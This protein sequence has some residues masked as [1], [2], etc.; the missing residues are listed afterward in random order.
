MS[1]EN[2]ESVLPDAS[3]ELLGYLNFSDGT[4]ATALQQSFNRMFLEKDAPESIE[5]LQAS[6]LE[7]LQTLQ[8]SGVPGF[9]DVS[10]AVSAV[11]TALQQVLPAYRKFHADLLFHLRDEDFF[12][13]LFL[14]RIFETTLR[15]GSE[16]GWERPDV[17]TE[18]AVKR[19]NDYVGY[20][21][22]AVLENEQRSEVYDHERYCPIPLYV[23]HV[24]VA[25]G[26]WR[27][28]LTSA[29]SFLEQIPDELTE[30]AHF[31]LER[32]QE[33][34]LD[35]RAHDH[36]HPVNKRTNYMFG[37]W[38][39][40]RIDSRGFYTRFVIRRIIL[41]ALLDWLNSD[42]DIPS[43][44]RLFDASVVLAGTILMAS[45]ISGSGPQTFDSSV[46]LTVLLPVVARY[47]DRFY[48]FVLETTD[49]GRRERLERLARKSRQ[50]FGHVR[51]ELN[52]YLSRY[53]AQQVQHRQLSWL[54]AS[55]GFEAASREEA[56]VIPCPA[57][58]FE[59]EICSRLVLI[60][61]RMRAGETA[62][63]VEQLRQ[64]VR[65]L[66]AGIRC[67]GFVDPWNILGFQGMFP[68]FTAREDAIPDNRVEVLL[69][70]M[71]QIFDA[72]AFVM[73]EAAATG[74]G[75]HHLAVQREFEQ[76]ADWWDRYAT[77]TVADLPQVRGR[78]SLNAAEH[79]SAALSEWRTAGESAADISFW[80]KHVG[81]F[82]SARSFSQVVSVLLDRDDLVAAT[83]LLIQW[84]S[85]AD[86]YGLESGRHSIH[87]QF[88]R[89]LNLITRRTDASEQWMLLRRLFAFLESN[90]GDYWTVPSLNALAERH[91]REQKNEQNRPD[92]EHLFD[93][94][95]AEDD[96][97]KESAFENVVYRDSTDDGNESDTLDGG[98]APGTTEF[99]V[100]YRQIEPRLKFLHTLGFLWSSAAISLARQP[101]DDLASEDV[102]MHVREWRTT[103]RRFL[104]DLS[105]LLQE[106]SDFEIES[107]SADVESNIEFDVQM[108]S[109]FLLMQNAISTTVEFLLAE[110]LIAALLPE[111]DDDDDPADLQFGRRLVRVLR[112][113]LTG[114]REAVTQEFPEFLQQLRRRPLL[115]VPFENGGHPEDILRARTL[116]AVIRLLLSE[117]PRLGMLRE[118]YRLL[119]TAYRMERSRRP[120]GQA[121]TEFDRLFRIGLSGSVES[122][123]RAAVHWK[124]E[125]PTQRKS[126][127]RRIR[128]LLD[129]YVVLWRC[130]R[131]T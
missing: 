68:L 76:L 86:S 91:R 110:R 30:P 49:G 52:M 48:Q 93:D 125:T 118:T 59:A 43:E 34:C 62:D 121:V 51:H 97:W 107:W 37:E 126:A 39:P 81:L 20:R 45:S 11:K 63:A 7:Q 64:C 123:L 40:D 90:A 15:S 115:Y 104:D 60:P 116:Q 35:V 120:P 128:R 8:K 33:L 4:S 99:E 105:G 94:E 78:E 2:P 16:H 77:T 58:R 26:P 87:T 56:V 75:G 89:L 50:P 113:V 54:Y 53:G 13:P 130:H 23:Q 84:L 61:R 41:D 10:Q 29:L 66:H 129:S 112:R 101:S 88:Q 5:A 108:Q 109:R 12:S 106:V 67:G 55:M 6:L 9:H 122:V 17:L 95:Q 57:A 38:D 47:R 18:A 70:I 24:G 103:V 22:V 73:A 127:F 83:G 82:E 21:P 69:E 3:R 80:K 32:V 1:A 98:L 31:R 36:L 119:Q 42:R 44:E 14:A 27:E 72:C 96:P 111:P 102:Q 71:E 74:N 28:L 124:L 131:T 85:Q 65:L 25:A 117:L 114:D 79:V 92:L 19:L 46:S 100:L